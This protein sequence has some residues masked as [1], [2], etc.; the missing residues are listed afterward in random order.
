MSDDKKLKRKQ[1]KFFKTADQISENQKKR[2][3]GENVNQ[4]QQ[5]RK[6]KKLDKTTEQI[7]QLKKEKD[8]SSNNYG[9][10]T[11]VSKL[12]EKG[13]TRK[14]KKTKSSTVDRSI[15]GRIKKLK[16]MKDKEPNF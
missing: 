14:T 4:N 6:F 15:S 16:D 3:K 12:I 13:Y 7:S 5:D 11:P 8:N 10:M 1:K 9:T 2:S